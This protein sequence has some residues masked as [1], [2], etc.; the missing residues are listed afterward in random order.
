VHRT[1]HILLLQHSENER[2]RYV[3]SWFGAGLANEDKLLYVDV[4]GWGQDVLV[5]GLARHGFDATM[6]HKSGQLEFLDLDDFL[7]TDEDGGFPHL[8]RALAESAGVR[9]ALRGDAVAAQVGR[10]AH[11]AVERRLAALCH[12]RRV[13]ALCQYDGRTT[14]GDDLAGALDLHPDWVYEADLSMHR[15]GHVIQVAGELDTLDGD[16]LERSL[17][18]MTEALPTDRVLALDLREVDALTLAACRAL[19]EG[20]RLFRERSGRV[21]CGLPAGSAGQL[22]RTW[23]PPGNPGLELV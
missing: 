10:E 16:I 7:T 19:V 12:T 3:A 1:G 2:L 9:L 4:A 5:P 13:S 21:R 23:V 15:R 22:L 11:I 14:Q 6:P 8:T 18:R 17:R 20:T